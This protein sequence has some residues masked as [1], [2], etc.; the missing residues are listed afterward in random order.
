MIYQLSLA[1]KRAD[2][3]ENQYVF[4]GL[5]MMKNTAAPVQ[6]MYFDYKYCPDY[7]LSLHAAFTGKCSCT[8]LLK[9][10]FR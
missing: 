10:V 9:S 6:K 2:S 8:Y 1:K 5:L 7:S 3:L 4:R